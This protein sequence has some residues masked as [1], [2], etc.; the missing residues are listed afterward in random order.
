M[1]KIKIKTKNYYDDIV[2]EVL[3]PN[4]SEVVNFKRNCE[5][6]FETVQINIESTNS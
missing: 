6:S 1:A 4:N 3:A 2:N 5:L